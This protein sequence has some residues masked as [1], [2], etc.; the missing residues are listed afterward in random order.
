M[1][2]YGQH[3][4]DKNDFKYL[5]K[6]FNSGKLTQGTFTN[7]FEENLSKYTNSKYA[8]A[9]NNA[10]NGL[11]IALKSLDLKEKSIVWTVSNSYVA[12]AN[13]IIHNN[14]NI[15]F[16]DIDYE[17]MNIC[18]LD[19]E[20]NLVLA[21]KKNRLPSALITVHF[22]GQ[23]NNQ[24]KIKKLS[25]KYGF[26]II[27]DA[28][29][30]LG[31]L[32]KKDKVGSC[33]YADLTV[34]SFHPVKTITSAEGGMITTNNKKFYYRLIMLRENGI[35]KNKNNFYNKISWPFYYEQQFLGYNFRLADLNASLGISQLNK[36]EKFLLKRKKINDHYLK[37]LKDLPIELPKPIENTRSSN[38]LFVARCESKKV[39]N[40]LMNFLFKNK[41]LVNL[42]Y[43]PI[44]L[45]PYFI[46]IKKINKKL[47]NTEI[48]ADKSISLP[49]YFGLST[50]NQNYV[51]DVI[52]K[53]YR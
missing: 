44:H 10:S 19:L 35:T 9:V 49:I 46:K 12:T 21:K 42:H 50:S 23:P 20:E 18:I 3:F 33:K 47:I 24:F 8:V 16:V 48:H 37:N 5:L 43:T 34:F 13:C 27:E 40:N 45:N 14:H 6:C 29:H 17:S 38:H 30:A 51:I 1:I 7:L 41:I 15:D 39:R 32:N 52:K 31:A 4:V 25:N 53:F 22:A 28:S 36:I 11:I 2:P 26:K